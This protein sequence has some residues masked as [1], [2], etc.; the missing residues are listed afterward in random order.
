MCLE[1]IHNTNMQNMDLFEFKRP[2]DTTRR[3][4]IIRFTVPNTGML[5]GHFGRLIMKICMSNFH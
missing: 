3:A 4:N 2:Y 5:K 1:E